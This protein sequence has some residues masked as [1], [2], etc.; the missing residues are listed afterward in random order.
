MSKNKSLTKT[1]FS[2]FLWLGGIKLSNAVFQLGILAILARLLTPTEFGLM[3]LALIVVSFSEIFNDLGFGP[4]ITQK[5]KI[6]AT[7]INTAFFSS[8]LFGGILVV[9]VWATSGL[10]AQ[11]FGNADLQ[12]ILKVIAFVLLIRAC[13]T[14]P[15]G[16][17][18]R[19]LQYK[20]L[21]IIQITSY[22]LGYG[23]VG[24]TLAYLGYGV[25][26]LVYAVLCQATLSLLLYLF[27]SKN[28]YKLEIDKESFKSLLHFGGGYSLSKVFSFAANRGDKIVIGKM[29][30]VEALGIYERS[31]QIV[32]HTS[33][34]VGEI[35]DKVLFS[36]FARKQNDRELIAKVYLDMTYLFAI[37]FM[38]FSAFIYV[39]AENLVGIL[40]G[41]NWKESVPVVKVF[42][43]MPFFVV[44]T[45]ISST[46]AKSLGDVYRRAFRTLIF[47]IL[48]FAS[49]L[50][51]AK[52]GVLAI[53]SAIVI[54]KI[55]DY[56]MAYYQ[57]KQLSNASM[58]V[59]L[60]N[61]LYGAL[62]TIVYLLLDLGL[63]EKTNIFNHYGS[64][65]TG[66]LILVFVYVFG[67]IFDP[68]KT[69]V[70]HASLIYNK[71]R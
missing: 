5:E 47:A 42:S 1:T 8:I 15:L 18:Y 65:L 30:G 67:A 32:R 66:A 64:L 6:S 13:T 43:A 52:W 45:R 48:V 26:S 68:K 40:L 3:G 27:F 70:K 4:A 60:V 41:S 55:I 61:H 21:S 24:I 44:A 56:L 54:C 33:G 36:P 29:L 39:N 51:F 25:W 62:L 37:V 38:P 69:I 50:Y 34:L 57:V 2:G 7:D 14:T 28:K 20:V 63:G 11:F 12:P 49:S 22:V 16:L 46:I 53:A 31:Y 35:V 58:S 9:L 10:V 71:K 23:G 19:E 17:M 59:F